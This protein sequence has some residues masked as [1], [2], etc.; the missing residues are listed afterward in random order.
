MCTRLRLVNPG[1]HVGKARADIICP[2]AY[3]WPENRSESD[4]SCESSDYDSSCESSEIS[5]PPPPPDTRRE[6]A[7]S[8]STEPEAMP[9]HAL[10]GQ[11]RHSH[12]TP[13]PI[14]IAYNCLLKVELVTPM[15]VRSDFDRRRLTL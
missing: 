12:V 4:S 1:A 11:G 15:A 7:A 2:T 10:P 14:L 5:T 13:Q 6:V 8:D 9:G 3:S